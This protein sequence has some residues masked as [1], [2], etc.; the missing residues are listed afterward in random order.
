MIF[1]DEARA[2]ILLW[3]QGFEWREKVCSPLPRNAVRQVAPANFGAGHPAPSPQ[4]RN[5]TEPP[6]GRSRPPLLPLQFRAQ[7]RV[8]GIKSLRHTPRVN[9]SGSEAHSEIGASLGRFVVQA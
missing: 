1:K 2:L 3:E 8:P 4:R 9:M 6:R 7:I 5:S